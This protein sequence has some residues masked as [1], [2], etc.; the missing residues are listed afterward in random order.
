MSTEALNAEPLFRPHV[1]PTYD[2]PQRYNHLLY[3]MAQHLA[4]NTAL[5]DYSIQLST[6][7]GTA[8][9]NSFEAIGLSPSVTNGA[10]MRIGALAVMSE[11]SAREFIKPNFG[12]EVTQIDGEPVAVAE[13]VVVGQEHTFGS[14]LH[15]TR[16]T[17][18]DDPPVLIVAPMSGHYS[19]LL[20]DTVRQLLPH[21]DVYITDWANAREVPLA[22]GEFGLSDYVDYLTGYIKNIGPATN[23]VAVCQGTVPALAAVSYLA[24]TEPGSQPNTMTMMAGPLDTAA[25]GAETAVNKFANDHSIEWFRDT[26][27]TKVPDKY[28]GAG[29]LVY[30][31]FMQLASFLGMN[32]DKHIDAHRDLFSHLTKG[33]HE[34]AERLTAFY[35]EYLAV[36]DLDRPFYLETVDKIFKR[37]ELA[38][39]IMEHRGIVIEP[40]AIT[41]TAIFTVEAEKDDICAPGQT[42]AV[43][44]WL[45]GLSP[46]Q[47]YHL[48]QDDIGHYGVFNGS[49]WSKE[50]VPRIESF[51]RATAN[52][53]GHDYH[54]VPTVSAFGKPALWRS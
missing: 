52:R 37:R 42:V 25:E 5:A 6:Q 1:S 40:A 30:P 16:E 44:Q 46:K 2:D 34:K 41:A 18:R 50:I 22:K 10:R 13:E 51:I 9:L 43:H 49:V 39:G 19:T 36:A 11:R 3:P 17:A 7:L 20:R 45:T 27:T 28:P 26:V 35:D 54:P 33:D 12:L 23:I 53:N 24:Q 48:V 31:G 32:L 4:A 47:Q 38:N 15:F 8:M 14:L 29:R 21:H